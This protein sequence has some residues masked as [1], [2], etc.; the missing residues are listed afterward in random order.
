MIRTCW[1][2][3]VA[4]HLNPSHAQERLIYWTYTAS[5]ANIVNPERGF[6]TPISCNTPQSPSTFADIRA[7]GNS[8]VFCYFRLDSYVNSPIAQSALDAFQAQMDNMRT[9]G[10][11][12]VLRFTYNMSDNGVDAALPQL[13]GHMDQLA[14]YLS[15]NKDVIAVIQ[16]GFIGSWGEAANSQHYGQIQS[17]SAQNI[18]DRAAIANKQLQTTPADRFV[19]IRF[20]RLKT[21]FNGSTALTSGE[22][23]NGSTKARQAHHNDSFLATP[24]DWG[25]YVN[26]TTEY[27]YMQAE[28]TYLPMGGETSKL[29]A[30]RTDCPTALKELAM[31]HWS[32]IN[33]DFHPEVINGWRN[34]GC[35]GQI[36]Q[37]LGYR[38]VLTNGSYATSAKPGG[39]FALNFTVRNDG[40]AALFNG[41]DVEVVLR[42]TSTGALVRSKIN[43]DPRRWLAGQSYTVS[44]NITLPAD[45]VKGNYAVLLNL[46]DPMPA[47]RS[48]PEYAIQLANTN[49]WE[50]STGFNNLNHT[51]S[52]SPDAD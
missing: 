13:Y 25:T 22:A 28:T 34:Q 19:Q 14:P 26:L 47:L 18:A 51:V 15:R 8:L 33:L 29:Y 37:K 21:Q 12:T 36:Q 24:D 48:R 40:W 52:I 3:L 43:V 17:M 45:L 50:P 32:F 10:V 35:F 11:K 44:Q 39:T 27:P 31:F 42:N 20:P 6:Y 1:L 4:F 2:M 46:P 30:P 23:F 7:N 41:R 5:G 38:L 9:G 16:S 49:T